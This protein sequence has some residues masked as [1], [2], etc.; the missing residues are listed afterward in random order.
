[1]WSEEILRPVVTRVHVADHDPANHDGHGAASAS[2]HGRQCLLSMHET[3]A[4]ALAVHAESA[5]HAHYRYRTTGT[6]AG[7]TAGLRNTVL[8]LP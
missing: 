2:A 4:A 6:A 3:A 8:R 5:E 1:M 7:T